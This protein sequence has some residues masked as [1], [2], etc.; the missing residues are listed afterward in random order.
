[1][2]A[3]GLTHAVIY[4]QLPG[5]TLVGVADTNKRLVSLAH[6]FAKTLPVFESLETLVDEGRPDALV[7]CTPADTHA[8]VVDAAVRKQV[9]KGIFVEKPLANTYHDA[10]RIARL[11]SSGR[12]VSLVGFQKRSIPSLVQARNWI[13]DGLLGEPRFFR[14]H[15]L[16]GHVDRPATGWK[17]EPSSGGALLEFGIHLVDLLE[18]MF[19]PPKHVK[20]SAARLHSSRVEDFAAATL[21]Y[22]S[23]LVGVIETGWSARNYNPSG[24]AIEVHGTLASLTVNEDRAI[25]YPDARADRDGPGESVVLHSASAWGSLPFLFALPENV[26]FDRSFIDHLAGGSASAPDFEFAARVSLTVERIRHAFEQ[27]GGI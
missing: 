14:S 11:A 7:V 27:S 26:L 24:L 23:G 10:S 15:W 4:S 22:A 9:L 6:G 3:M 20:A 19:G 2:G 1:M 13:A 17:H 18:W 16:A 8:S 21:E 12:L 25:L 5:S